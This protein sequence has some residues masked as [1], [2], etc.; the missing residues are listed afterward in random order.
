MKAKFHPF[1]PQTQG[2]CVRVCMCA[3]FTL[4]LVS[5]F[6]IHLEE[7]QTQVK[8]FAILNHK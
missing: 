5:N 6:S 2:A 1:S 3:L 8:I 4:Q 7:K